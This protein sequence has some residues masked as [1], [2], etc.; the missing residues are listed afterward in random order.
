MNYY[1]SDLH[2]FHKNVVDEGRNFDHRPF[3]TLDEMHKKI[4][5]NWNNTV[6]NADDVYILGD[7][8]WRE[9]EEAIA[10]T[11]ILKGRKHLIRGNHDRLRDIRYTTLF[12]EICDYKLIV[13]PDGGRNTKLV[14]CH[15]PIA[16]WNFQHGF[17]D[18][19][20]EAKNKAILLYGHVHATKEWFIFENFLDELN[21]GGMGCE[22][23]NVGCMMPYIDYTPRS[24]KE[25]REGFSEH[26]KDIEALKVKGQSVG[27][28]YG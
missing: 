13:D 22:A 16:F 19:G 28:D 5:Q 23:Y 1:I 8:L 3:K 14:L 10:L 26:Q 11:S 2:L 17:R 21:K 27:V 6:T 4:I 24:L 7:M 18:N 25:I 20:V 15:Y 9:T 12:E